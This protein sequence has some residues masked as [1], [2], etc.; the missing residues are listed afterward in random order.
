[1]QIVN[2]LTGQIFDRSKE[3]QNPTATIDMVDKFKK[4]Q[5]REGLSDNTIN[6]YRS[7]LVA[8]ANFAPEWP[9]T[10]EAIETF[11]DGYQERECSG[12]TLAEYWGRI[13][14]WFKWAQSKGHIDIKPMIIV[15]AGRGLG[16]KPALSVPKTL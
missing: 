5:Q 6:T 4:H 7:V 12:V 2:F 11:L 16:L 3:E 8:L 9:P 15:T 10:V 1:M 13:R 14:T